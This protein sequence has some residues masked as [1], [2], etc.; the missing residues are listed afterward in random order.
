MYLNDTNYY[1]GGQTVTGNIQFQLFLE[2]SKIEIGLVLVGE[3]RVSWGEK[4]KKSRNCKKHYVRNDS[5]LS[6]YGKSTVL[7]S[8]KPLP[9]GEYSYPF[10]FKIPEFAP[11]SYTYCE[12]LGETRFA[13]TC[14]Y[15]LYCQ[16]LDLNDIIG[17]VKWPLVVLQTPKNIAEEVKFDIIKNIRTWCFCSYET[18][19]IRFALEKDTIRMD[20]VVTLKI[21]ADLTE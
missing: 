16:I 13:C 7:K 10:E 20:E 15:T 8:D 2:K 9:S 21:N 12:G 14:T 1:E 4:L 3:E 17:R 11:P 18:V 5:L 6:Y 19:D